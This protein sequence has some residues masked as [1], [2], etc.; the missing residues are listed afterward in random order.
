MSHEEK[1]TEN[2]SFFVVTVSSSR[3][4][5]TDESGRLIVDLL[6]DSVYEIEKRKVVSDRR[7]EISTCMESFLNSSSDVCL[8]SGGTG[9]SKKDGTPEVVGEYLKRKLPGFGEIFRKISFEE[10]GPR[11]ILSRATAGVAGEK[12]IFSIPGSRGAVETAMKEI[13]VPVAGHAI[14][15]L[16]K[17]EKDREEELK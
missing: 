5:K 14:Y 10:I 7:E 12:L 6:D 2:L 13:I 4:E 9:I 1:E 17:E 8:L 16:N 15:E 3:T 11:A